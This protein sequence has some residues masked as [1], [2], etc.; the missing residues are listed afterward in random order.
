M[1][2]LDYSESYVN[3]LLQIK[4][5]LLFFMKARHGMWL[6]LSTDCAVHDMRSSSRMALRQ[7]TY[8]LLWRVS[9]DLCKE[10][11]LRFLPNLR[12]HLGCKSCHLLR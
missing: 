3:K 9:L 11:S 8:L 2:C 1:V 6:L 10:F 12:L 5:E 7:R 4:C